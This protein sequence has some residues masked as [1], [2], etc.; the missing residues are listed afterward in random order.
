[1]T[2]AKDCRVRLPPRCRSFVVC[3]FSHSLV[4]GGRS[5]GGGRSV[6][7]SVGGGRGRCS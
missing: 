1:V 5:I 2:D 7:R 4:G 3:P 6:G